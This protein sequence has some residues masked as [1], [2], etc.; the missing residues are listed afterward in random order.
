[1]GVRGQAGGGQR[2]L[3]EY[4]GAG[5]EEGMDWNFE[6]LSKCCSQQSSSK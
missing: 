4:F 3:D 2:I 1:M 6:V 5:A